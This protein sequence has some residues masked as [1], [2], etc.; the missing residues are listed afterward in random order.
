VELFKKNIIISLS[1]LEVSSI[2]IV[3]VVYIRG[4]V[5]MIN[6]KSYSKTILIILITILI[7]SMVS[8]SPLDDYTED[9]NK[10]KDNIAL[11]TP[12]NPKE[13]FNDNTLFVIHI[14]IGN[15]ERLDSYQYEDNTVL[16]GLERGIN[17]YVNILNNIR[18]RKTPFFKRH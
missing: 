12:I 17:S 11:Y 15:N 6:F 14:D 9:N 16:R 8:A 7:F 5:K 10:S 13:N 2:F 3:G 18:N 1:I 4:E